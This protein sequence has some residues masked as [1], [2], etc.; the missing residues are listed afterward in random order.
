MI[1]II[2]NPNSTEETIKKSL[3]IILPEVNNIKIKEWYIRTIGGFG[4]AFTRIDSIKAD[5]L[6]HLAIDESQKNNQKFLE[7]HNLA[8]VSNSYFV[9]NKR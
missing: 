8:R 4:N 3:L 5:S 1:A 6:I 2:Y 7:M 9:K